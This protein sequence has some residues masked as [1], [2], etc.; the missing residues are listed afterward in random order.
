MGSVGV[1]FGVN[2]SLGAP[3]LHL[4]EPS[5]AQGGKPDHEYGTTDHQLCRSERFESFR[6]SLSDVLF[7]D[8][9]QLLW[10]KAFFLNGTPVYTGVPFW[11][12]KPL[13]IDNFCLPGDGC[14]TG[15]AENA[16][17]EPPPTSSKT[18]GPS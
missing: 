1:V 9:R 18:D 7:I 13:R 8:F 12:E 2:V 14:E 11:K 10:T 4:F 5:G 17:E 15:S 16:H 6:G 3:I